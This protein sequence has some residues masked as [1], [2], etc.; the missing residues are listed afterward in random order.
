MSRKALFFASLPLMVAPF[1]SLIATPAKAISLNSQL[2]PSSISN[3]HKPLLISDRYDEHRNDDDGWHRDRNDDRWRR[4]R[5]DRGR[6]NRDEQ[7]RH[8][9]RDDDRWRRDRADYW[10]YRHRE[11]SGLILRF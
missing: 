1:I 7:W 5:Y 8:H 3:S 10:R 11:G 9:D 4:E 6:Q 2:Q